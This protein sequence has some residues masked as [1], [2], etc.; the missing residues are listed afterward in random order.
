MTIDNN[1]QVLTI[2]Q[3]A[4]LAGVSRPYMAKLVKS[5]VVK[6]HQKVGNQRRVLQSTV[7]RWHKTELVRQGKALKRLAKDLDEEMYPL[8]SID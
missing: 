8:A 7:T 4:Q 1:D 5:G 6:L 2:E 3:A